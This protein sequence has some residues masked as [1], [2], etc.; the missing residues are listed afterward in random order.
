MN[1]PAW[2]DNRL[3]VADDEVARLARLAHEVKDD[4]V[5][6]QI[7]IE[8]DLHAP[9]V[10]VAGIEFQLLPGARTVMPI[11]SWQLLRTLGWMNW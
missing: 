6:R 5:G 11:T 7:K 9:V 8:V 3:F 4:R 10:G 1:R 2:R